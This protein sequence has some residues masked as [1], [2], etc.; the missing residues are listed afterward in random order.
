MNCGLLYTQISKS[1]VYYPSLLYF[2]Y[3][4][5]YNDSLNIVKSGIFTTF[6]QFLESWNEYLQEYNMIIE[7][8]FM[9]IF[10][11]TLLP[12]ETNI[13]TILI[14]RNEKH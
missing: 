12:K 13:P 14:V 8:H 1:D 5:T 11:M 6:D 4:S 10:N 2:R 9:P 7:S 3:F